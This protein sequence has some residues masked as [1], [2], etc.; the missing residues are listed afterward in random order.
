MPLRHNDESTT[1]CATNV[2][3][4]CNK[5]KGKQISYAAS[6]I[7]PLKYL[8]ICIYELQMI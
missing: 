4:T 2:R 5:I 3:V 1:I 6:Q 7:D 8:N